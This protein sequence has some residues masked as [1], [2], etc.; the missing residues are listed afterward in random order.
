MKKNALAKVY[1]MSLALLL[2]VAMLASAVP[3]T[4]VYAAEKENQA[5]YIDRLDDSLVPDYM[6]QLNENVAFRLS[7]EIKANEEIS[8]I[9]TVDVISLMNAYP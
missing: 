5:V 1:R 3:V 4:P 9:I 8:V 7:D 6:E 2:A